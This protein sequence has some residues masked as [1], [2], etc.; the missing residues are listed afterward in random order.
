MQ[1]LDAKFSLAEVTCLTRLNM[2]S[3]KLL[4]KLH[5]RTK[6]YQSFSPKSLLLLSIFS[7]MS[8]FYF[9]LSF[10][11]VS[12]L[13]FFFVHFLSYRLCLF[14][15]VF[16]SQ[17]L[18]IDSP[19]NLSYFSL[20]LPICSPFYIPFTFPLFFFLGLFLCIF[21]LTDSVYYS[22]TGVNIFWKLIL[23]LFLLK[24]EKG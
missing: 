19:L 1:N 12:S 5:I 15:F 13:T 21:L 22:F 4:L 16:W 8:P 24:K 6:D 20:Y 17:F 2:G 11:Y 23:L 10:L 9:L 14:L 7:N 3:L 18:E